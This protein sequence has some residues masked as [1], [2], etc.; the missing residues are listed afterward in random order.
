MR[1]GELAA[2]P[3]MGSCEGAIRIGL[4]VVMGSWP[5]GRGSGIGIGAS[6]K[7]VCG[8]VEWDVALAED[9]RAEISDVIEGGRGD[10]GGSTAA[11]RGVGSSWVMI[12]NVA[13]CFRLGFPW[14]GV[15]L[16]FPRSARG[17]RRT[18]SSISLSSPDPKFPAPWWPLSRTGLV[19]SFHALSRSAAASAAIAARSAAI[20]RSA[21]RAPASTSSKIPTRDKRL[22]V[23]SRTGD[24]SDCAISKDAGI[25]P[26]NSSPGEE[27]EASVTSDS[28]AARSS[29][30][31]H[32]SALQLHRAPQ[33][34]PPAL[35]SHFFVLQPELWLQE[36]HWRGVKLDGCC[37]WVGGSVDPVIGTS[38]LRK[39]GNAI[40]WLSLMEESWFWVSSDLDF[41]LLKLP[42][43]APF[44]FR[45][46]MLQCAARPAAV[47]ELLFLRAAYFSC[48]SESESSLFT[49]SSD[50][51][52]SDSQSDG[53][54][55]RRRS[56]GPWTVGNSETTSACN[57][58]ALGPIEDQKHRN[59]LTRIIKFYLSQGVW[60]AVAPGAR[61][62]RRIRWLP[63]LGQHR[64]L[65]HI[66]PLRRSKP[67]LYNIITSFIVRMLRWEAYQTMHLQ[68][69]DSRV[70]W[71]KSRHYNSQ[72]G[73]ISHRRLD[74][75]G[76]MWCMM[77][78]LGCRKGCCELLVFQ[79]MWLLKVLSMSLTLL[80]QL[81]Q[82]GQLL[83]HVLLFLLFVS[84]LTPASQL[85]SLEYLNTITWV[86]PP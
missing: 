16:M 46:N 4:L 76:M 5:G 22:S 86:P 44:D 45:S 38:P 12:W 27:D 41:T 55:W 36:Q 15:P 83:L 33:W 65:L 72:G 21:R 61:I 53:V 2:I 40:M 34:P 82:F 56:R 84:N 13:R 20:A 25:D 31:A 57:P 81:L 11:G 28:G 60:R 18:L 48:Q 78:Y 80:Q 52:K 35:H 50:K 43:V 10:V 64:H 69:S 9:A 85:Q 7:T 59:R 32:R 67:S 19:P 66:T 51:C 73:Q 71:E 74:K 68:A 3:C 37:V 26:W 42:P 58:G 29:R 62:F 6:E 63:P 49:S 23:P 1:M 70:S 17:R 39:L 54:S 47:T 75:V 79:T 14:L 30:F 24:V 8:T 77:K